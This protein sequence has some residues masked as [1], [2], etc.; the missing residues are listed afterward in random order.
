[1]QQKYI[2]CSVIWDSS[3]QCKVH[4]V[5]CI[6]VQC[7]FFGGQLGP[8]LWFYLLNQPIVCIF[9]FTGFSWV[10]IWL[11]QPCEKVVFFHI[12]LPLQCLADLG[13]ARGCST[14]TSVI[15]WFIQWWFVKISLQRRHALMV[16]VGAFSHKIDYVTIL[17]GIKF[18]LL[19]WKLQ[20]FCLMDG[21]CLLVELQR[22]RVCV[23]SLRSRLFS[24]AV[25]E[26]GSGLK[27]WQS[28]CSGV[29]LVWGVR[30]TVC[31]VQCV[32]FCV[33]LSQCSVCSALCASC[34]V[35]CAVC[36][37]QCVVCS[38]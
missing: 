26:C 22:W 12:R 36:S 7:T 25:S 23:C 8:F 4:T 38:V 10:N 18:A 14:N 13:E 29:F 15:H 2:Q 11:L 1:M 3:V 16:E 32:V 30:C 6:A 9:L 24:S 37:V 31:S 28:H 33:Q 20:K 34:S 21:F 19:V 27:P 17:K 5:Q 35:L